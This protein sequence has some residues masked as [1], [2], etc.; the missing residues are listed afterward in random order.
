[1]SEKEKITKGGVEAAKKERYIGS[2]KFFRH[3]ILSCVGL[4]IIIPTV[5]AIM[6]WLRD[7][8]LEDPDYLMLRY[9]IV[10][11]HDGRGILAT[12]DNIDEILASRGEPVEGGYYRTRMNTV[13]EFETWDTPSQNAHIENAPNNNNT[14]YVNV[15]IRE[16]GELVYSSPYIPV[17]ARLEGFALEAELPAG[18][19]DA[20]V[21]Y[22]LVDDMFEELSTVSVA[23][24]LKILG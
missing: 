5:I 2:V 7:R 9:Q 1:M 20:V 12:P 4:A 22:H 15:I 19:H 14:V 17:G 23:V 24:Q 6:L 18:E 21:T 13:W 16:T 11:E 8:N 3:L 10:G